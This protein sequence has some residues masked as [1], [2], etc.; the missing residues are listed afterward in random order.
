MNIVVI[1]SDE[2]NFKVTTLQNLERFR[3]AVRF[4]ETQQQ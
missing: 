3:N 4:G 1:P 2:D